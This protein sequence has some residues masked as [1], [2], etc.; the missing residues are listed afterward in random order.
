MSQY[1]WILRT[2]AVFVLASLVFA[3]PAGG[4]ISALQKFGAINWSVTA[5]GTS[6][7]VRVSSIRLLL[8]GLAGSL[9]GVL[10]A[11]I[12]MFPADHWDR[13][14]YPDRVRDGQGGFCI[15]FSAP[16]LGI[17]GSLLALALYR[18]CL[19]SPPSRL[20][21]APWLYSGYKRA[22]NVS[23]V[24]AVLSSSWACVFACGFFL[25]LVLMHPGPF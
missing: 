8:I 18:L 3:L 9:I 4:L 20:W 23:I 14:W 15:I 6:T 25:N 7:E 19:C 24:I 11:F 16:L 10:L 22:Q 13:V 5:N 12:S 1:V 17:L 21:S 2:F